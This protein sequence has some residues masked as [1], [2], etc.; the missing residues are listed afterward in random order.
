[1]DERMSVLEKAS[2][3]KYKAAMAKD[4]VMVEY[5]DIRAI[6]NLLSDLIHENRSLKAE[7]ETLGA[8]C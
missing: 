7:V 8:G 1:M 3:L 2:E 5:Q 6:T 4:G